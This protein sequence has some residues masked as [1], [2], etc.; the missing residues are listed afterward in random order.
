MFIT[1]NKLFTAK[2]ENEMADYKMIPVDLET[3]NRLK[4][5]CRA[6]EMG[7]RAQ[8]TMV[9]KLVKAEHEKLAVAK[10]M[11]KKSVNTTEPEK[12]KA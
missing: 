4:E 7:E 10:L 8:G 5:L 6:Y 9:R 12:I 2:K 11:G 3:Y 1:K